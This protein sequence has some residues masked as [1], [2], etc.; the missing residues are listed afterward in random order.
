M[1]GVQKVRTLLS[2]GSLL[3]VVLVTA[4][5]SWG[6]AT[7]G[8]PSTAPAKRGT[9]VAV[10]DINY[11]FDNY[12]SFQTAMEEVQADIKSLEQYM[13]DE[14][15]KLLSK[16]EQIK[17]LSGNSSQYASLEEEIANT[18]TKL[19]L[20]AGR[21]RKAILDKEA[22]IYY[23]AYR[24]VEQHIKAFADRY[25]IDMVMRFQSEPMDLNNRD[26]VLKSINQMVVFQRNLNITEHILQELNRPRVSR[27]P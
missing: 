5:P 11:L 2:L 20:E 27:R 8:S 10:I 22:K 7:P 1:Q 25:G 6:Q 17:S 4:S 19:N 23:N 9:S 16:A 12:D 24:Q 3:S 18:Q 14:R 21:R 15:Q 26:S 13:R